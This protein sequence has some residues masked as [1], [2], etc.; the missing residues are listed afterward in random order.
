MAKQISYLPVEERIISE[1]EEG[2]I[3]LGLRKELISISADGNRINYR[4]GH[5]D[6]TFSDNYRDPEEKVRAEFFVELVERYQYRPELI[7]FEAEVP[8]RE[9]KDW[10]KR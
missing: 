6:G 4:C 1:P 7:D 9:P 8:R 5:R 3:E 2:W 10:A